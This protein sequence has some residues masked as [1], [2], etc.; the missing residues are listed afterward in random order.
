MIIYCFSDETDR[1][2]GVSGSKGMSWFTKQ[3]VG[4]IFSISFVCIF[5]LRKLI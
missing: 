4:R 5:L 1:G 3:Q 2:S